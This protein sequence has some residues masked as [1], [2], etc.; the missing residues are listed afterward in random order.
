[1]TMGVEGMQ[2]R[3]AGPLVERAG[4]HHLIVDGKPIEAGKPVPADATHVHF[5]KGQTE[6]TLKR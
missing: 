3:P 2:M 1:M 6:T 4:H 5:G